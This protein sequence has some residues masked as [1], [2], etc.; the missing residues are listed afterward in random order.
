MDDEIMGTCMGVS[1][2][3][4]TYKDAETG[5]IYKYLTN[6]PASVPPGV[7]ALLYKSRW[8]IEK[9]FDEFKNK[10]G[11]TKSWASGEVA[12]TN[13]AM[14]LCLTHNLMT[15]MEELIRVRS[16]IKNK[17]ELKRR[18]ERRDIREKK[19]K[20]KGGE[21]QIAHLHHASQRLTQ[22][23]VKFIRWLKNHLDIERDWGRSYGQT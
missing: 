12:K 5:I 4:V 18:K 21:E 3:R 1:I 19:Q 23:T 10:L 16:G 15:L 22:R 8:D 20:D 14:L 7:I 2:R 11:E 6:L 9:V 17:A 13:H